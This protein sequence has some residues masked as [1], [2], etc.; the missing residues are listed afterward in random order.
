M[1]DGNTW[2]P[3]QRQPTQAWDD[4]LGSTPIATL[5]PLPEPEEELNLSAQTGQPRRDP[6]MLVG[7]G[8]LYTSSLVTAA[9]FAK[10]WWDAINMAHFHASTRLLTWT[11][12]RPGSWQSMVWVGVVALI[13]LAMMTAPA[14]AAFQAWNGHRWSRIAGIIAAAV[15]LLAILLNDW[16]WPAIP[17]AIVGAAVLWL[18][19]VGEYFDNWA[20]FR[21]EAPR[22][23]RTFEQVTYGPLDRYRMED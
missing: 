8:L 9:A 22:H 21:A 17:L 4:P 19:K 23:P 3:E 20:A 6:T 14:V 15:S 2:A 7:M 13:A 18:G 10:F 1:S 5:P 16:A 11:E 12:P